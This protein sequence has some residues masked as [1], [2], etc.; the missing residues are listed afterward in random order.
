MWSSIWRPCNVTFG[1]MTT[2]N[3]RI[4]IFQSKT[5]RASVLS[6]IPYQ[7]YETLIWDSNIK[8]KVFV[9]FCWKLLHHEKCLKVGGFLCVSLRPDVKLLSLWPN[10][11]KPKYVWTCIKRTHPRHCMWLCNQI[12]RWEYTEQQHC[13]TWVSSIFLKCLDQRSFNFIDIS[14]QIYKTW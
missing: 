8:R 14:L 4:E 1:Q 11:K 5:A 2:T 6:S 12:W 13:Q 9:I 7:T 3:S 10:E